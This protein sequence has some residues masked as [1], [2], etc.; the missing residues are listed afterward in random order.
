MARYDIPEG[1]FEVEGARVAVV[2]GRFNVDV[3]DALLQGALE[4]LHSHGIPASDTTVVRVPGAFELPL[5]ARRLAARGGFDA[6]IT[7]G[8]VVRGDT[9]HFD[10][11]AGECA[12]GVARVALDF[13]LPVIFGVLT[14]DD[15]SQARARAGGS[16]GN[17]G[18]EA[19][20]AALEMVSLLRKL[21]PP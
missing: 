11:V 8:A 10:Y 13:D 14:T 12:R 17:K 1:Q 20:L 4:T 16:E 21:P 15:L 18:R 19:A 6:I 9:P 3:V 5:L 2:A 7:L